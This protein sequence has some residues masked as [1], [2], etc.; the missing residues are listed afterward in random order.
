MG[1]KLERRDH[2]EIS[3]ST[4]K[5]PKEIVVFRKTGSEHCAVGC[6]HL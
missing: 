4:A 6:D 1:L 5:R 2:A 3:T